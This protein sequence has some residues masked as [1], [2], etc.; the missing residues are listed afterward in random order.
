MMRT[1]VEFAM[2]RTLGNYTAILAAPTGANE[3]PAPPY[4]VDKHHKV[5]IDGKVY[6]AYLHPGTVPAANAVV[7]AQYLRDV[8][9]AYLSA[10][11]PDNGPLVD[12]YVNIVHSR[13]AKV[14]DQ[15]SRK[16][17]DLAAIAEVYV[18]IVKPLPSEGVIPGSGTANEAKSVVD[19]VVD[20]LRL[21]T[22]AELWVRVGEFGI[23]VILITVGVNAALKQTL[24]SSAPQ[25]PSPAKVL[26][27]ASPAKTVTKALKKK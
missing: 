27:K 22:K 24:G 10:G 18:R 17:S 7:M 19:S 13:V 4:P 6:D 23:G 16:P 14:L 20:F 12:A 5:T 8:E 11:K 1:K 3:L 26:R 15:R 9:N 25:I 2:A 21:L